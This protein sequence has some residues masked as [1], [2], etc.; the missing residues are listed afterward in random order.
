MLQWLTQQ[1]M[2]LEA[3]SKVGAQ[4]NK[5]SKKR[6]TYLPDAASVVSTRASGLLK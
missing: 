5:R 3:E 4:K 6:T 1:L 2:Q